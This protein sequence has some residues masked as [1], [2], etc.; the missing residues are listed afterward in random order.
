M[1]G[2]V[3]QGHN[4]YREIIE[5][6]SKKESKC[7]K[8]DLNVTGLLPCPSVLLCLSCQVVKCSCQQ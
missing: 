7:M 8:I 5:S 2:F 1:T 4:S 3:V 6:Q